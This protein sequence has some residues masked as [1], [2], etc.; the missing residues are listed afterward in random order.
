[1]RRDYKIA[2]LL[3]LAAF[4]AGAALMVVPT[5]FPNPPYWILAICFYGGIALTLGLLISAVFV[6]VGEDKPHAVPPLAD[7]NPTTLP[8]PVP[9]IIQSRPDTQREIAAH[10]ERNYVTV[11][12]MY[13]TALF[14]QYTTFQANRLVEIYIGKWMKVSGV[15]R[16]VKAYEDDTITVMIADQARQPVPV[17]LGMSFEKEWTDRVAILGLGDFIVATGKIFSVDSNSIIMKESEL[18]PPQ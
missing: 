16:N 2:L 10:P 14:Q 9:A 15:V 1:M 6:A 5:L 4:P 8:A 18:S 17:I 3:G 12:P 13:L 11:S 7:S